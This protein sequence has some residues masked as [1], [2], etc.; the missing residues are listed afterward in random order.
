MRSLVLLFI[1]NM[2][3]VAVQGIGITREKHCPC[4]YA[5]RVTGIPPNADCLW[6]RRSGPP[7]GDEAIGHFPSTFRR[8]GSRQPQSPICLDY[9]SV[10]RTIPNGDGIYCVIRYANNTR[11][12]VPDCEQCKKR[13]LGV[14]YT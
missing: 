12:Y 2:F 6:L 14:G 8:K 1:V 3:C 13:Q 7:C 4:K 10:N 11:E 5:N 9:A